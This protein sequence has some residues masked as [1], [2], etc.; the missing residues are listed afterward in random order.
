MSYF[1][2]KRLYS[3]NFAKNSFSS[4]GSSYGQANKKKK[5]FFWLLAA[6]IFFCIVFGFWFTKNILID[7]PDV[8][9]IKDMVFSEATIIQDRNGEVLY[10]L[11]EENREYV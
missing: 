5:I 4:H 2:Q 9:K 8:T 3:P 7:L 10:R 11:F 1:N 6:F